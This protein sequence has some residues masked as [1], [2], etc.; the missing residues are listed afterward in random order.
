MYKIL[1]KLLLENWAYPICWCTRK[2]AGKIKSLLFQAEY[3]HSEPNTK[4]ANKKFKKTNRP[5]HSVGTI[6]TVANTLQYC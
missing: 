6:Q 1:L 2:H 5:K 3:A 4:N